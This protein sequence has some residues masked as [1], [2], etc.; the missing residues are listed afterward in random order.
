VID[1][2]VSPKTKKRQDGRLSGNPGANIQISEAQFL[3]GAAGD[4]APRPLNFSTFVPF[5]Q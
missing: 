2:H 1:I 4:A 5:F 3:F